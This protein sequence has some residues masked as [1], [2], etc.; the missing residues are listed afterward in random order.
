MH[1]DIK[2][3]VIR[4]VMVSNERI[5]LPVVYLLHG[6]SGNYSNWITKVPDLKKYADE[7]K[8]LIVCPDGDYSSWY[9]DS[10]VDPSMRYET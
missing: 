7:Y 6:Y 9:F 5:R 1:K 4:P 3:V 8:L 2:C 10:P